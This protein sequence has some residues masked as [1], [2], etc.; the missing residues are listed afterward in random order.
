MDLLEQY[1]SFM[2]ASVVGIVATDQNLDALVEFHD[3]KY[4]VG[5]TAAK[6]TTT[7]PN[8]SS[9]LNSTTLFFGRIWKSTTIM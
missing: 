3:L 8:I 5:S 6:A 2:S 1:D 7:P 9:K 4:I